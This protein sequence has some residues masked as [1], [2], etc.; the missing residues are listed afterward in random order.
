MQGRPPQHLEGTLRVKKSTTGKLGKE[1][2]KERYVLVCNC[3]TLFMI[4]E[5]KE[6]YQI[7]QVF[8]DYKCLFCK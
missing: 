3:F 4:F 1:G 7:F 8:L 6:G 5:L 2:W